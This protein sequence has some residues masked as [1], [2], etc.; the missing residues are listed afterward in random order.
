[1]KLAEAMENMIN[2][3]K[4]FPESRTDE[5]TQIVQQGV[6]KGWYLNEVFLFALYRDFK[7]EDNLD[8]FLEY[9]ITSQWEDFWGTLFRLC[10]KREE[11]LNEAKLA[12]ENKLYGSAIH[13]FFSQT[14]GIFHDKFG[15][16]FYVSRGKKA[17]AEFGSYLTEFIS[18]GAFEILIEQYK[19]ASVFRR[20]YNE[21]YKEGFSITCT[22][23]VRDTAKISNESDLVMPNRHGVLHGSHTKY[24]SKTNALKCFSLLLFVIYAIYGDEAHENM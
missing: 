7:E 6:S 3:V 4:M 2:W 19:D 9:Q 24:G 1:M 17:E 12:Y 8:E 15:T 21:V 20:M 5:M 22:D 14:D 23:S 11:I 16:N 13:V 10:P 18:R